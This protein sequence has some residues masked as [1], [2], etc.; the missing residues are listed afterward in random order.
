MRKASLISDLLTSSQRGNDRSPESWQGQIWSFQ[1]GWI[2]N[3]REK[4]D[5]IFPIVSQWGLSVAIGMR[6]LIQSAQNLMQPY[7]HPN[8]ATQKIWSRLAY[9]LQRYSSSK[10]WHFRHSRAS[11]SKM[12]GLIRPK[13]ELD[14]AFM[15]VLVTSNKFD[16]DSIKNER[17]SMATPFSCS[18]NPTCDILV[19][20]CISTA[21]M[22]PFQIAKMLHWTKDSTSTVSS[23]YLLMM[24]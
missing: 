7:P 8:D 21:V 23:T 6:I 4:V 24:I 12:S 19:P 13:I 15:P 3:N 10:K 9:W 5:I 20:P 16:D 1:K 2:K 17:A 18:L 22:I 11:N 14:R